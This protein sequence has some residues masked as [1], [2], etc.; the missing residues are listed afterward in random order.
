MKLL[1]SLLATAASIQTV[2]AWGAVG[3]EIVATIAQIHLHPSTVEQLCDILPSYADCHLAPVA[4]WADKVRM[5]M[6][7]S[8][9][10]HYVNGL[11]DHPS[12]HCVFGEEGW[13]GAPEHNV[14]SAVRNTTMWLE[15]GYPGAEEALK[16]L[17]HFMGDLHQPLHL[18]GRDKGG[19][20]A[21]VKFDG[22]ITN[23][24]SVW[25]SRLISKTLR[26]IPRNYTLP[27]PSRRIE[28][29]LLGTIYD[30]YIR[31]IM[32]EG[33]LG[34]FAPMIE[35]WTSCPTPDDSNSR[36]Y[37]PTE[38]FHQLPLRASFQS[39]NA[40]SGLTPP[41]GLPPT[42]D[43]AVCPYSWAAPMHALNCD[44]IWPPALDELTNTYLELDT[45]EYA[46]RIKDDWLVEQLLAMGGIRL[47]ATLN[48]LFAADGAGPLYYV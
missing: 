24:H 41:P 18:T 13:A 16:F 6:R 28:D 43:G 32:F 1:I 48:Y 45:P 7:W 15:K 10:L 38:K 39:E 31:Q 19:N 47:A 23:L 5:H 27:L 14:L 40:A 3:H 36:L 20:G 33:V 22:R 46:G 12:Q 26:T 17:I 4:A 9:T 25:D 34:R 2:V 11:G 8:S 35:E 44:I 42:D 37:P 30:P 29:A 21:K